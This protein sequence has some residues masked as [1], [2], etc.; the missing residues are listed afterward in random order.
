MPPTHPQHSTGARAEKGDAGDPGHGSRSVAD[1][2]PSSPTMGSRRF[3]FLPSLLLILQYSSSDKPNQLQDSCGTRRPR[4]Q[5]DR[6]TA[7][8]NQQRERRL[9]RGGECQENPTAHSTLNLPL[10]LTW[11]PRGQ[12]LPSA[13]TGGLFVAAA[14]ARHTSLLKGSGCGPQLT[15]HHP[16]VLCGPPTGAS[17]P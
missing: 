14:K 5:Q 3:P 8:T 17:T 6:L 12:P 16:A 13:G 1:T 15:N 2:V 10:T 9:G 11:V 7:C 4:H